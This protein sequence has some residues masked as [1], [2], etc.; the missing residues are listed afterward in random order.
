[1]LVLNPDWNP[2]CTKLEFRARKIPNRRKQ[3]G[4][5]LSVCIQDPLWIHFVHLSLELQLIPFNL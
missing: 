5:E 1:M 3:S 2:Y 4:C